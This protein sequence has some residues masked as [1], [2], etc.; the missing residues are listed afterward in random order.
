MKIKAP[1]NSI[2]TTI[3]FRLSIFLT[4]AAATVLNT[5][6]AGVAVFKDQSFH[7]DSS[8]KPIAY[9]QIIDNVGGPLIQLNTGSSRLT[10]DRSKF[11]AKVEVL[12]GMPPVIIDESG[13][14]PV[15][16]SLEELRAFA[17]KYPK[18][19]PLLQQHITAM[20]AHVGKFDAGEIRYNGSWISKEAYA[21]IAAK[22]KEKQEEIKNQELLRVEQNRV[23]REKE[24]AFAAAQR[25]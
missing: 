5:F 6:G 18:S 22:Q 7:A 16:Q 17:A 8:A 12:S 3:R 23:R 11:V 2:V 20:A 21:A 19:A 1:M 9:L 13:I 24:E 25:E 15:R 14:K 4:V 10:I